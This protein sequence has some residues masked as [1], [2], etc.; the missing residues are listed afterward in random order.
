MPEY[1]CECCH[2]KTIDKSKYTR[3]MESGKHMDISNNNMHTPKED[4]IAELRA[5]IAELTKT[6]NTLNQKIDSLTSKLETQP[7]YQ[8]AVSQQPYVTMPTTIYDIPQLIRS[9]N[10]SV[11]DP[12][13]V[14]GTTEV[15]KKRI[16]VEEEK[17]Y[18]DEVCEKL[19]DDAMEWL[20]DYQPQQKKPSHEDPK[21]P[22]YIVDYYK[23]NKIAQIFIHETE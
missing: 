1:V 23:Y 10:I 6:V 13:P 17:K 4:E 2:F 20:V 14:I 15:K 12:I 16:S 11:P 21:S 8:H 5:M 7:I 22:Y 9:E 18:I 19:Q 3:H